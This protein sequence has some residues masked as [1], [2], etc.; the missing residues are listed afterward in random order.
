MVVNVRGE[1]KADENYCRK[2]LVF[3]ILASYLSIN[4]YH[5]HVHSSQWGMGYRLRIR[6]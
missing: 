3:Y 1:I 5:A 6:I 2:V 4:S